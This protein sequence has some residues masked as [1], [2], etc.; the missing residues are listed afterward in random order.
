MPATSEQITISQKIRK[1]LALAEGNKNE[2]ERDAAMRLAL[3]LLAKHNLD[4]E[5]VNN[6]IDELDIVE[7]AIKLKL[8]P[9]IRW[10]LRASCTLYYTDYIMSPV[11]R[12]YFGDRKEYHPV[13]IGTK[14][15]IA[16]TIELAIWLINSIRSESNWLYSEQFERRS[17]RLGASH[18]L[19]E[20]AAELV[21]EER[22]TAAG[23]S[24]KSNQLL[25]L[26]NNLQSANQNYLAQ[27][28]LKTFHSK[29]SYCSDDA[30]GR[31]ESFGD[32]VNLGK[33]S[34]LKA[35]TML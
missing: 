8:E 19:A 3:E 18:K 2:H 20:R 10:V 12:G 1:L 23:G 30:Y 24:T 35:I 4:L 16:V 34:K 14:E 29:S 22:V 26:R 21:E 6:N 25:V 32:S 28:N 31:G 17:F 13:F 5:R 27:M 15:N 33:K 9:W 11:Y 7:V